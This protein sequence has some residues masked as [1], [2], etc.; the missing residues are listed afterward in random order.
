MS[1]AAAATSVCCRQQ[2]HAPQQR[3][4]ELQWMFIASR[5]SPK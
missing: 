4:I 3:D 5:R 2:T 1:T